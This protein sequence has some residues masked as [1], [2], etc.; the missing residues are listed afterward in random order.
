MGVCQQCT[1]T[2]PPQRLR[3][4]FFFLV[5]HYKNILETILLQEGILQYVDDTLICIPSRE[6]KLSLWKLLGVPQKCPDNW[7]GSKYLRNITLLGQTFSQDKAII[8][9]IM[10]LLQQ[11]DNFDPLG[12]FLKLDS[13]FQG[14]SKTSQWG[15]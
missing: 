11:R 1:W 12:D 3:N 6:I 10:T 4:S 15:Y 5:G 7:T 8:D 9:L 14:Y 13:Q 2:V